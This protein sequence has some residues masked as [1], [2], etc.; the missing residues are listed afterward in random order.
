MK[1]E[2]WQQ[3]KDLLV[4]ALELPPE[5]RGAF[6]DRACG[7]DHELR[8][9][10]QA[11]LF[12]EKVVASDFLQSPAHLDIPLDMPRP[13][14]PRLDGFE[15]PDEGAWDAVAV[16][17]PGQ[18]FA[19]RFQLTRKL[20]EGGM[21]Q[22][23]L[24]EQT[25]PVR[26]LVAVKLIRAGMYDES[27]VKRF[28]A[29]RQSL[30]M[31]DH[32]A[33][34]KVFDA[35]ATPQGQ[36]YFVMEYVPGLP[37]TEYCDQKKLR[38]V[39]RLQLFIQAC[40]GVQHAHQKAIIHRDLKP[41]N[42]L[43]VQVD[44]KPVPRIID[45][46]LA[47]PT[48]PHLEDGTSFTQE[49]HFIGTPGYMSPEQADPNGQ[50][51][52]T[53]TDVYSL[54]AVL[55]VLLVGAQPFENR[56]GEKLPLHELLRRLREEEPPSPSTKV[57]GDR[58]MTIATAE[59]R[60]TEPKQLANLLRGDLDWITMKALDK[61]RTRRY[62]T[63]SELAADLRRYLNHEA[64]TARPASTGYRLRK[65]VRRHQVV[66]AA[67]TTVVLVLVVGVTVSTFEAIRARHAQQAA[68]RERD[69]AQ[70]RFDDVHRLARDVIFN[71]ENQLAAI[72]GTTQARKDL[73]AVAIKYLDALAKDASADKAL[74]GELVAAYLKVGDIQGSPE[75]QDL[76]DLPA[77]AESYAK[78]E[79][80]ARELVAQQPTGQAKGLL[81]RA[82]IAQAEADKFANQPEKAAA[83]AKEALALA[84]ERAR[85]EPSNRDAQFQLGIALQCTALS[86]GAKDAVPYLEEEAS[87]FDGLFARE[88]DNP[89]RWRNAALPHKYVA[90][91][92][93][94]AGDL[95]RAFEHLKR[96]EDLDQSSVRAAP[97]NPERK[98][99]LAIDLSQWG[100]YYQGK[101]DFARAIQYTRA[102]LAIR[103]E[104]VSADPKNAQA[105]NKLSYIL[106]RLGD[107]QLHVS[108]LDALASY[109][110]AKTIALQL[111]TESLRAQR[112]AISTSGMGNA[113][114]TLGDVRRSCGAY[115]ESMKLYQEV[116]KSSPE[117]SGRAESTEKAYSHCPAT[118]R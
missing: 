5:K 55:Y 58:E 96:A 107:L 37:I 38:I 32:P 99:D 42:I 118:N 83:K 72:P 23:W 61:D 17:G 35:G 57:S 52:D 1:S 102:S 46:G 62:G 26:R 8:D 43:I 69:L 47:K 67:V 34:A 28:Q 22:V 93:I 114:R 105:Q 10:I 40:E 103:R 4:Q 54:G 20:G 16:S 19:E 41:A 98:M 87:V 48:T 3:M 85:S 65:Y 2:Q 25:S 45:F 59:S 64:V 101:K 78:A 76:G 13:R 30:A 95:D 89:E 90:A 106:T 12:E 51:V 14:P 116:L 44:G 88:P 24:A 68:L 56:A 97:N 80:L 49:G 31:M 70:R 75:W 11:L 115:A 53:R 50:D 92:L 60:G 33:I 94:T 91:Y 112:L 73:V 71:L 117:Y 7:A 82:L 18:V 77:A 15:E 86:G 108:A 66:V 27:V 81:A 36:P 63:P 79:G 6:L 110:E 39:D 9:E 74:Q 84:R 104:L 113:Y 111:Q 29:E 100:E 109:K 21:G